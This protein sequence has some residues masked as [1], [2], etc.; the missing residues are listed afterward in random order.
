MVCEKK[1]LAHA[2]LSS[3]GGCRVLRLEPKPRAWVQ[4]E[5]TYLEYPSAPSMLVVAIK[6]VSIV[7][8][9]YTG[10]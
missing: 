1:A 4:K 7:V 2:N 9:G 3:G 5:K 8:G 6:Q 10:E